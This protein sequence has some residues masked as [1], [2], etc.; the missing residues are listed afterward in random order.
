MRASV[1][2]LRLA[3]LLLTSLLVGAGSGQAPPTFAE[4]VVDAFDLAGWRRLGVLD[5]RSSELDRGSVD[6][7]I[8][9]DLGT[10]AR[11]RGINPARF[12]LTFAP[13][14]V[15]RGVSLTP[16]SHDPYE[17]TLTVVGADGSRFAAGEAVVADKDTAHFRLNDVGVQT[18]ELE[19]ERLE[20]DDFVHVA[21][22]RVVGQL[23]IDALAL[24][25]I[26]EQLPLGGAF[27][28]RVLGRDAFGGKPDLTT[29]A[30]LKVTPEHALLL[31]NQNRRAVTRV[32]GPVTL[33]PRLG[34]LEG[35]ARSVLVT[36]LGAA[37]PAPV[38]HSGLGVVQLDLDGQAPFE[39]LRRGLGD[40]QALPVGRCEDTR[41][42]DETV[43]PGT[44]YHYSVRRIDALGNPVTETSE[45]QRTR[46]RARP[47]PGFRAVGRL[48]VL[49]VL[50]EESFGARADGI[51][52]SLRASREFV[53]RHTLGRVLLDLTIL[54]L[55][56]AT[57]VI[58]GPDL[59]AVE[60]V[61]RDR[62]VD[63][64]R[65][66]VLFVMADDLPGSWGNLTLNGRWGGA[67]ARPE[68]VATI[69]GAMGPEPGAAYAFIHELQHVLVYRVAPTVGRGGLPTGHF[70]EDHAEGRLAPEV[71][72]CL[73]VGEAW[74]ACAA[75]LAQLSFF[76]EVD[77]PFR[78][79]FELV[80]SDGDGL[81][82]D[83]PRL[84]LD[85][86]RLGTDPHLADT[87]GDGLDDL[88]ELA[89]GVFRH[90][91]PTVAD[92]DGDGL[93]DGV[94]PAPLS[95]CTG[96][97]PF[98]SEPVALASGPQLRD[99]FVRVSACWD[100]GGLWLEIST[101]EPCDAYV[102]LDGSGHLGRWAS[103]A[104]VDGGSDVWCGPE[105]LSLRAHHAPRG[106]FQGGRAV[107]GADVIAISGG[108]DGRV[109]LLAR[110]P[111][112]LG[113]GAADATV[114]ADA[115][116]VDGLQLEP[117]RVLGLAV[118]ARPAEADVAD[119]FVA[120][121]DDGRWIG[122]FEP[123]QLVDVVL[124]PRP[125]VQE[126]AEA[127]PVDEA[128]T[129]DDTAGADTTDTTDDTPDEPAGVEPDPDDSGAAPGSADDG[130][131]TTTDDGPDDEGPDTEEA[132][133]EGEAPGSGEVIGPPAP[134]DEDG[135]GDADDDGPAEG[136]AADEPQTS[137]KS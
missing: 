110:I 124:G 117:G 25:S 4:Q 137:L 8:D 13:S 1:A 31:A 33:V 80:D 18:V 62:G 6:T 89:M 78:R 85:E 14:Q 102:D 47:P 59:S 131:D 24:G 69:P 101:P 121:P 74:D 103:D 132:P 29:Q 126:P 113:A 56:G 67:M 58:N 43:A 41:W 86:A 27:P 7:L 20:R 118:I 100:D 114:A 112:Q 96:V 75:L 57:P 72:A 50:Y 68:P 45:E 111:R 98:G 48:P 94:D 66:G 42:F 5:M 55:P 77:T 65:Y 63:D 39:I 64:E 38:V 35:D 97:I 44:S 10:L 106:V 61:L 46:V 71:G 60:R 99:G 36:H 135:A 26:P 109:R 125:V 53:Y 12:T 51:E 133:P 104:R 32:G 79:P 115:P 136:P 81:A 2:T 82:D 119:P 105:R 83:D 128:P 19:V 16:G 73:D 37:P 9:G 130:P 52:E 107:E 34:Q 15:V 116:D 30:M 127:E 70:P 49:V 40:K 122:L 87:D 93:S 84:P 28:V 123:H 88:A 92:T 90:P 134:P 3:L 21:E 95:D 129:P 91:D 120:Y 17:V 54:R 22:I 23:D 11:T 76:A 108:D